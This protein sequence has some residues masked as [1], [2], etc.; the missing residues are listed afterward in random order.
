MDKPPELTERKLSEYLFR[1]LN[2]LQQS[3]AV[4]NAEIIALKVRIEALEP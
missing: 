3:I 2:E 1:H 4:L